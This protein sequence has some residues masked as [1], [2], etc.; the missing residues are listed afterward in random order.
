VTI[1]SG[2]SEGLKCENQC[3]AVDYVANGLLGMIKLNFVNNRDYTCIN[4]I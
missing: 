2:V 3:C 4:I 1:I